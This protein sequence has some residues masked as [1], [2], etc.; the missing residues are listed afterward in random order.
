MVQQDELLLANV[1][2]LYYKKGMS[3]D[4]IA[5]NLYISRSTV[6]RLL[7]RALE[8][9]VIEIKIHFPFERNRELEKKLIV[10]Y[11]LKDCHILFTEETTSFDQICRYSANYLSE[12]I[13]D[14]MIIGLSS[15]RTVYNICKQLQPH[16]QEGLT[17]SAVKGNAGNDSDYIYDS[18]ETI[19]STAQKFNAEFNMIYSPLFV[20]NETVR[21]Y[22]LDEHV[23]KGALNV[24]RKS[25]LLIASV[26]GIR[27]DKLS[28]YRNYLDN[29]NMREIL[30]E[31]SA[32]SILGHFLN[33]KG[34]YINSKLDESVIG[35][36]LEEIRNIKTVALVAEGK[37]KSKGLKSAL[38]SGLV[39]ILICDQSCTL[40]LL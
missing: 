3:Q 9:G 21:Q 10:K 17:F 14:N 4:R 24:A 34:E 28:V 6:S 1:A 38:L 23:I 19:R 2:Y 11:N 29:S 13:K 32:A 18:P 35:L 7:Q 26:G 30:K 25:D 33:S 22:L 37:A 27:D 12:I 5:K 8:E 16:G 39:D 15:G 40:G 36:S 20:F 31:E